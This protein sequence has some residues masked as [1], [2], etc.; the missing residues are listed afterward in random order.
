MFYPPVTG[1][2]RPFP[3]AFGG[4]GSARANPIRYGSSLVHH[5]QKILLVSGSENNKKAAKKPSPR[6]IWPLLQSELERISRVSEMGNGGRT[7]MRY[8][9]A[10]ARRQRAVT[11]TRS[12]TR[13]VTIPLNPVDFERLERLAAKHNI[14]NA[15]LGREIIRKY[16][17]RHELA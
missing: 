2:L 3:S 16:L 13:T 11:F 10:Y 12:S 7:Y 1:G 14:G 8:Q 15:T 6:H 9:R 17:K 5:E 4:K